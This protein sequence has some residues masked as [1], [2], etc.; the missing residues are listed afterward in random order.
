MFNF[1]NALEIVLNDPV[2]ENVKQS[3]KRMT[4]TDR[5]IAGFQEILEFYEING[6]L[7]EDCGSERTLYHSGK[8][9]LRKMRECSVAD[10]LILSVYFRRNL[11]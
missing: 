8:E 4:S 10:R 7:P 5:L 9:Y 11:K 3:R 6:R 1:R 2:F